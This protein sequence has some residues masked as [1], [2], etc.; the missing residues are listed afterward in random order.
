MVKLGNL[1]NSTPLNKVWDNEPGFTKWLAKAANLDLL[2]VALG[3]DLT[4]INHEEP[5]GDFAADILAKDSDGDP[6]VIENQFTATDHKHLGQIITYA[7]GL[8]AKT[9]IWLVSNSRAEHIQ[10]VDWLNQTTTS[11]ANYWL[12][13]VELLCI[14]DS[15]PA[16]HFKVVAQP[17]TQTKTIRETTAQGDSAW[18]LAKLK[19]LADFADYTR[20]QFD[21]FKPQ[22]PAR[23]GRLNITIKSGIKLMIVVKESE[24]TIGLWIRNQGPTA[25]LYQRLEANRESIEKELSQLG[26]KPEWQPRPDQNESMVVVS[27]PANIEDQ[28]QRDELFTWLHETALNLVKVFGKHLKIQKFLASVFG[29]LSKAGIGKE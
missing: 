27:R 6:V 8:G 12:V 16:P 23:P 29:G 25:G 21:A 7:A 10:A 22:K 26:I 28:A 15:N 18:L 2:A 3:L 11:A 1:D 19:F 20:I 13:E 14:D 4:P 9:I 24:V 5:V 17:N